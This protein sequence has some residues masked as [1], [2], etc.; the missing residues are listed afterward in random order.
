M[1]C[2]LRMSGYTLFTL[3]GLVCASAQPPEAPMPRERHVAVN[4]MDPERLAAI[5]RIVKNSTAAG[6][7][8]SGAD[9]GVETQQ[10]QAAIL[11]DIDFLLSSPKDQSKNESRQQN[12]ASPQ[13]TK[14][15]DTKE[16]KS[17]QPSS[18]AGTQNKKNDQ[19]KSGMNPADSIES[20]NMSN[21]MPGLDAMANRV[22]ESRPR[23]PRTVDQDQSPS[24]L[25]MPIDRGEPSK[26]QHPESSPGPGVASQP[27]KIGDESK[28]NDMNPTANQNDQ[29]PKSAQ[30]TLPMDKSSEPP[31]IAP[32]LPLDEDTAKRVWGGPREQMRKQVDQYY[33]ER[34][35]PGYS[36]L[37]KGYY[38]QLAGGSGKK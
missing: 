2:Q 17:S 36:S 18:D 16:T 34:F 5:E 7:R 29:S 23:R 33:N 13:P 37:L 19:A 1:T 21:P 27:Q 10:Q 14:S 11:K 15:S 31:G 6:E 32:I 26:P 4:G 38:A 24:P 22:E 35:M 20:G 9:P 30:T 12:T 8:L 25:T 3:I 28:S